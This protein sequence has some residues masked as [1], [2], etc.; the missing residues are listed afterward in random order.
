VHVGVCVP[1]CDIVVVACDNCLRCAGVCRDMVTLATR[2][3]VHI[4]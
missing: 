4:G 3:D 2:K 1:W